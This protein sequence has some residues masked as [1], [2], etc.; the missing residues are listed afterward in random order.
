[1]MSAHGQVSLSSTVDFAV[2]NSSSVRM[3]MAD[4]QRAMGALS[5][6]KDAYIPTL[7][8]GSS[9]GYSYGFPLGEP[10]IFNVKS[11]SLLYSFTQPDYVRAAGAALKGAQ[12]NLKDSQDQAALDAA[13]DYVQLDHD[14]QELTAL[15]EEKAHAGKLV[16][17]EQD[18]LQ[19]GVDPRMDVIRAELTAAQVDLK[20][21]HLQDDADLLR[22]KLAHLTGLPASS[23]QTDSASI[24]ASPEFNSESIAEQQLLASNQG[25]A[26][27]YA[28]AKSKRYLS[29]ADDKS[30]R[31]LFTFGAEYNRFASFNNY[32]TYYTNFQN[33]NVGIGIQ[34]IVPLFD[35][36]RSAKRRQSAAIAARA[37]A[38]AD[39]AS[40]QVSE[41]VLQM[42][43]SL[44]ELAAQKR[45]AQLQR[46]L[47]QEQLKTIQTQLEN[48][49]GSPNAPSATP[50]DEQQAHIQ[51][52]ER[53][54]EMLDADFSVTRVELGL[55]RATGSILD[56]A[57]SALQK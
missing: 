4:I 43:K 23:F 5:E 15:D 40:N 56:W 14:I 46:E 21:I 11:N 7:A 27:A 57:H 55:L 18:R 54:Q 8:F 29:F 20:H 39:Q 32:S 41:Q 9:L 26:A 53:Y 22:Q 30:N 31:P 47:A 36:S 51:E 52:R 19:A 50:K 49:S 6:T 17:I 1:M 3:A 38:Q 34:I 25:V 28:N 42:R 37:Q 12:L 45:V 48:G 44:A 13:L 35:A 33:D 2:K 24:P 16:T 10:S